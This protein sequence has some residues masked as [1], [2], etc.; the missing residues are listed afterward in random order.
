M[1]HP[2]PFFA[3]CADVMNDPAI[4]NL[5]KDTGTRTSLMAAYGLSPS[6][7]NAVHP[8]RDIAKIIAELQKELENAKLSKFQENSAL[9]FW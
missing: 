6:Q 7:K 8:T 1:A 2:Y 3:F 9:I 5:Y 4:M